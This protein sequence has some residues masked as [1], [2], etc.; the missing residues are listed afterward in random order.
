MVSEMGIKD[1]CKKI[2]HLGTD[3][4]YDQN[5]N[6]SIEDRNIIYNLLML[7]I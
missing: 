5:I 6:T 3:Y 1:Q 2:K 7:N 4:Y